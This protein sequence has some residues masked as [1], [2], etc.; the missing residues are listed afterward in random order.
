MAYALDEHRIDQ[1][2]ARAFVSQTEALTLTSLALLGMSLVLWVIS[3]QTIEIRRVSDIGLIS[4]LPV[5]FFA[6]LL[7]LTAGFGLA[8]ANRSN[9]RVLMLHFAVQVLMFFGTPSLLED[10]PRTSSAWRLAGISDY[11]THHH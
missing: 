5:S 3:L 8:V 10:G 7:L 9:R 2:P 1:R 4:V 11:I 6:A